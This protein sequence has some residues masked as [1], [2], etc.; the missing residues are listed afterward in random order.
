[1]SG[2]QDEEFDKKIQENSEEVKEIVK[3][4]VIKA[5]AF[6]VIVIPNFREKQFPHLDEVASETPSLPMTR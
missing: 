5:K 3:G 1:M 6:V 2:N 4:A